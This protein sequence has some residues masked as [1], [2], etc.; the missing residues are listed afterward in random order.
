VRVS[1][2]GLRSRLIIIRRMKVASS[3]YAYQPVVFE[4]VAVCHDT[5][6]NHVQLADARPAIAET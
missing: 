5:R 4:G 3:D 1:N 2:V 6:I